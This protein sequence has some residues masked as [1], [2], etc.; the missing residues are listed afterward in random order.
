M[1]SK[2]ER[3]FFKQEKERLAKVKILAYDSDLSEKQNNRNA[4]KL[5]MGI[6]EII[7]AVNWLKVNA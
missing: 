2:I 7:T 3:D 4:A 6:D 5:K 1:V